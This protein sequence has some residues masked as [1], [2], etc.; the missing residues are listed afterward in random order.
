[1]TQ[2]VT[3]EGLLEQLKRIPAEWLDD[4]GRKVL[5]TI[6]QVLDR[7]D[8]L[9]LSE[10]LAKTILIENPYA[11]DVF[12]LFLDLSQDVLAN[13]MKA[14]GVKG[15]FTSIRGKC[16][17]DADRIRKFA[18]CLYVGPYS[19]VGPAYDTLTKFVADKGYEATGSKLTDV[20]GDILKVLGTKDED[21]HY[22]FVTDGIGWYR[23]LSDL[24]KIVEYHQRGDI[25]MI[26]TTSTLPELKEAIRRIMST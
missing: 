7:L 21:A 16:M 15:D 18:T 19:E 17:N 13:E 1:M 2:Q 4:D 5:E 8:D 3:L 26:Y 22:F 14:R 6:P 11:L 25:E 23:R 9:I 12:R 20:L 24:K 10:D